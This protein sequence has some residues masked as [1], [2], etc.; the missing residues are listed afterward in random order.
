MSSS[1][2]N[3]KGALSLGSRL[4]VTVLSICVAA[5]LIFSV[6]QFV[7]TRSL[8]ARNDSQIFERSMK[9]AASL[10]RAIRASSADVNSLTYLR[11]LVHSHTAD[12]IAIF[13]DKGK[14]IE[15]TVDRIQAELAKYSSDW[16]YKSEE[17][18]TLNKHFKDIQTSLA[19]SDVKIF[20]EK[21]KFVG[22]IAQK[23]YNFLLTAD[24]H[25]QTPWVVLLSYFLLSLM[26]A[27][28]VSLMVYHYAHEIGLIL[29]KVSRS[30]E[31][32]SIREEHFEDKY[33]E[34]THLISAVADKLRESQGDA[35]SGIASSSD[36]GDVLQ[37][38]QNKL[39]EKA[40]PRMK[41]HELAVYPRK[42]ALEMAEFIS[43]AAENG[44]IDILIGSTENDGVDA[45]LTKHRTQEKFYTLTKQNL[46][47]SEIA[48]ELW[49]GLMQKSELAPGLFFIRFD[50]A[51]RHLD[52]YRSGAIHVF[53]MKQ[54]GDCQELKIGSPNFES[55]FSMVH[56]HDL[57]ERS[58]FIMIS[59]ST[60]SALEISLE[61]F[62]S[63]MLSSLSNAKT[64]RNILL[65]LLDKIHQSLPAGETV[66]GL[67]AVFSEK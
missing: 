41:A 24:S 28:I 54:G 53:E 55:E 59:H 12:E 38:L 1:Q 51:S 18:E 37:T 50:E 45:L 13:N 62:A 60:I 31:V 33:A 6:V 40:F 61:D 2:K 17:I 65:G 8:L 22:I 21:Q 16:K 36:T 49:Q 35:P 3:I 9:S 26:L 20:R 14:L 58:H 19:G 66:P 5:A 7:L 43:G 63:Q 27:G 32:D 30:I 29:N 4:T 34:I 25:R 47:T 15:H 46:E 56:G 67:I 23:D 42:P 52:I 11:A 64:A 48:R 57:G 44:K 10:V 39:F